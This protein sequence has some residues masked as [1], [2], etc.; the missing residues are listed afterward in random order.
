MTEERQKRLGASD[1][2]SC[3]SEE[4]AMP[5]CRSTAVALQESLQPSQDSAR[6]MENKI[7]CWLRLG[8]STRHARG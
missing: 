2:I 5:D 6:E 7:W 1:P 3:I 4:M 8:Q